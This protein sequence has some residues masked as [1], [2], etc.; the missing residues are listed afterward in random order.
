[1]FMSCEIYMFRKIR[2]TQCTKMNGVG[3]LK[4]LFLGKSSQVRTVCTRPF[5]GKGLGSRLLYMHKK[6]SFNMSAC[7]LSPKWKG[8]FQV[9][10]IRA[11]FIHWFVM[12]PKIDDQVS[13]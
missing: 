10:Y 13:R 3:M 11:A 6:S 8:L 4:K 12:R 1:M 7:H 5:R 9:G 2:G